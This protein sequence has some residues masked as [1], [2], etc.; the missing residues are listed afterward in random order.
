LQQG[1]EADRLERGALAQVSQSAQL[2]QE[3]N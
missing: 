3:T 2:S 1:V